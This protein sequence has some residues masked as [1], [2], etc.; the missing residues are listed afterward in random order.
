MQKTPAKTMQ[1]ISFIDDF[2]VHLFRYYSPFYSFPLQCKAGPWKVG[3]KREGLSEATT[4]FFLC[5]FFND[6]L[7]L[8]FSH[9]HFKKNEKM[10]I[11]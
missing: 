3:I 1:S 7:L 6:L 9:F 8:N 4:H 2:C 5:Y 10:I 11:M